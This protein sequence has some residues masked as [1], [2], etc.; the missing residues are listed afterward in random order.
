[1]EDR[2]PDYV[3]E[4]LEKELGDER[5]LSQ[6]LRALENGEVINNFEINYVTGLAERHL[7]KKRPRPPAAAPAAAPAPQQPAAGPKAAPQPVP[8]RRPAASLA[9]LQKKPAKKRKRRLGFLKNKK[10]LLGAAG[11]A[12]LVAIAGIAGNAAPAPPPPPPELTVDTDLTS[13]STGDFVTITGTSDADAVL[14][15]IAN[16]AG[17]SVWTERVSTSDGSYSTLMI[18]GGLGWED[19]GTYLLGVE[20]GSDTTSATFLFSN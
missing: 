2:T 10:V 8:V 16:T 12:V 13:Y 7:G 11:L 5:I 4:L 19:S 20:D 1:M 9:S 18:A 6:I 14:I 17:E 3:K 15:K